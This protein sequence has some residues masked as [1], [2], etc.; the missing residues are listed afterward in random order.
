MPNAVFLLLQGF[1]CP[2]K[3]KGKKAKSKVR[4]PP[5]TTSDSDEDEPPSHNLPKG[6]LRVVTTTEALGEPL[7]EN[8][9]EGFGKVGVTVLE[10]DLVLWPALSQRME[11]FLL[12]VVDGNAGWKQWRLFFDGTGARLPLP[13]G[14]FT[15]IVSSH[16]TSLGQGLWP[17]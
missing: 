15:T 7:L 6:D 11:G 17:L 5:A 3:N 12:E 16:T 13:S 14:S 9:P 10:G 1:W 8:V 2:Q 4:L